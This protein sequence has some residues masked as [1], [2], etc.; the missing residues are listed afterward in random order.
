MGM[1][2]G[3]LTE[4]RSQV[5][6]AAYCAYLVRMKYKISRRK[7]LSVCTAGLAVATMPASFAA[8]P[9]DAPPEALMIR[10]RDALARQGGSLKHKD[11]IGVVD[12][13]RASHSPRF[14]L[15]DMV[16]GQSTCHLVAHG[17]GSDPAHTG[18]VRTFSN[19]PGSYASSA[20]AYAT[21]DVYVGGH[22][23]SMRLIG[24][25]A[26]NNNAEARAIVIHAAWYVTQN[27]ARTTGKLGRS[28]GCFAVSSDSLETVLAQLGPGRLI[29]A[30]KV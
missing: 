1:N 28:E 30:D 9:N 17:R 16:S 12:F 29:Y 24:L 2:A 25:D 14:F 19:T 11:R 13:A 23:R 3:R 4:T 26:E 7:L 8:L 6:A 5:V 21:S 10:A 15:V 18:F 22:G 20:G 27:M